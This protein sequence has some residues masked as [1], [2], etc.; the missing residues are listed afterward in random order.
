LTWQSPLTSV[1]WDG[2]DTSLRPPFQNVVLTTPVV[3]DSKV[4]KVDHFRLARLDV[5][6]TG[7]WVA[8]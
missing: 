3:A 8:S 7:A 1:N 6:I 4:P 2:S 5:V